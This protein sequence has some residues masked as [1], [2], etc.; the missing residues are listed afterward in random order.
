MHNAFL[1]NIKRFGFE[2]RI[3]FNNT[4]LVIGKSNY[5]TQF[6]NVYIAYDLDYWTT[7]LINIFTLKVYLFGATNIAKRSVKLSLLITVME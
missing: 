5:A 1:P 4:T 7:H 2:I 6:T 3:Q